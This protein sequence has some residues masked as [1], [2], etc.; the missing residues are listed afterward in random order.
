MTINVSHNCNAMKKKKILTGHPKQASSELASLAA[1]TTGLLNQ[2]LASQRK[3]MLT[4]YSG[5][6][7]CQPFSDPFTC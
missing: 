4:K 6:A 5:D 1:T 3:L 2:T 7:E